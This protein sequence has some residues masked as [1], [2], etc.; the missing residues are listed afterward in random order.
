VA[1]YQYNPMG[2]A[3]YYPSF[4]PSPYYMPSPYSGFDYQQGYGYPSFTPS[5]YYMPSPYSGF[6]YQQGYGYPSQWYGAPSYGFAPQ[7]PGFPSPYAF[8]QPAQRCLWGTQTHIDRCQCCQPTRMSSPF[9]L[10][11]EYPFLIS[12]RSLRPASVR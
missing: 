11:N 6:D 9:F 1:Y 10:E 12:L 7:S 3:N 8:G 2:Y 4:T 5:L